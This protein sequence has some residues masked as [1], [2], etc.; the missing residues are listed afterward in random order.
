M[1]VVEDFAAV[2]AEGTNVYQV[3]WESWY[4]VS[5]SYW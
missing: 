3:V 2:V 4:D 5:A 1:F